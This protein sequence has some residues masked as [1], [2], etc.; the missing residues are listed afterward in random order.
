[1]FSWLS[2]YRQFSDAA[3][4]VSAPGNS[5]GRMRRRWRLNSNITN[6]RLLISNH[7]M[8]RRF[9][10]IPDAGFLFTAFRVAENKV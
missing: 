10:P 1:M 7:K 3:T 4:L 6:P 5:Y 9:G 2:L 8:N